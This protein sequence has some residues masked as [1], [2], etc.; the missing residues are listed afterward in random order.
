[1]TKGEN[2][3]CSPFAYL[4]G[5]LNMTKEEFAL[6]VSDM[7]NKFDGEKQLHYSLDYEKGICMVYSTDTYESAV[8]KYDK[9]NGCIAIATTYAKLKGIE[10]PTIDEASTSWRA[11]SG[12]RYY[13]IAS[14][15]RVS[16]YPN[17]ND[18]TDD[19]HYEFGNYFK[20][21]EQ[22]E[23]ALKKVKHLL[24]LQR[25]HDMLCPDYE[26]DWST[27]SPSKYYIIYDEREHHYSLT[28][29][30]VF[31]SMSNVYFTEEAAEKA[32]EILNKEKEND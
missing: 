3:L 10:I 17:D 7:Y 16:S 13:F 11:K 22:A 29:C 21:R 24:K 31:N 12:E 18:Y 26:P 19:Y 1:M 15:G 32:C 8:S 6:W 14:N 28:E 9:S 27:R 20:T 4:K 2:V 5:G 25:L 30:C 23:S